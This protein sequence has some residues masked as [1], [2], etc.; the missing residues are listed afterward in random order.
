MIKNA[1]I[2][3]IDALST[4]VFYNVTN[5]RKTFYN[6]EKI[7]YKES[8]EFINENMSKATLEEN[9]ELFWKHAFDE[10]SPDGLLLEFGVFK[11]TSINFFS[12]QL[13]QK[14]DNRSIHGFDSFE[15]LSEDWTGT[16][17][18]QATFD[19]KGKLPKVNKNVNLIKG[20]VED[21]FP[22][23]MK[24]NITKEKT[25]AFMH[26]D[27]DTYSPTKLVFENTVDYL[28]KGTVIIFDELLGY[29]GWK[30][31]EFKALMEVIAPQWEYEFISFCEPKFKNRLKSKFVRAALKITT[32]K[33]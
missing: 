6:L 5:S 29:P 31:N 3:I 13:F 7:S 11:G 22:P 12:N 20:W 33:P 23:F 16:N 26:L 9:I 17:M 21:T 14:G 25:I 27:M 19:Q 8:A 32:R 15:G 2:K 1:I 30:D 4:F 28:K 10:I 18:T 24:E